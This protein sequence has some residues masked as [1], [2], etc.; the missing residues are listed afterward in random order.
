VFR[1]NIRLTGLFLAKGASIATRSTRALSIVVMAIL[2]FETHHERVAEN[3][4]H[5]VLPADLTIIVPTFN[6]RDNIRVL[7]ERLFQA[8]AGIA[9]EVVFVD[10]DST[11]GTADLVRELARRYPN[12]RCLQ[13]LG[14]RGLASACI[15]GV[16]SSAAPFVAV[17]DA[18]LQHD[19]SL[20]PTMLQLLRSGSLDIVIGSRFAS[21]AE[22]VSMPKHRVQ[23][24]AIGNR[25]ARLVVRAQ[26]TDP[27]SGF[28]MLRRPVFDAAARRLSAQGYKLLV[29]LFASSPEPLVFKEIGFRFRARLHG[30]SKLDTLIALEYIELLVDK[31]IGHIVPVRFVFFMAVGGLGLFVHLATLAVLL[32]LLGLGFAVAQGVATVTAMTWNFL[33]NNT[34]TYRDRRLHGT[35]LLLGLLSFYAVCSVGAVANVGIAAFIFRSERSWW[36]AGIAGALMGSVWNYAMSSILT[37]RAR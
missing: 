17:M 33:L 6:E 5:P 2:G 23:I 7:V 24:S 19:E 34:L 14:R 11:D 25:L 10:D 15:E 9:W 31:L 13:R 28:F 3:V 29:D 4:P 8:L 32:K 36:L 27:L 22:V 26:L 20:L 1:C 12:V 18:D 37:W 30:E 35:R 16:L 21:D